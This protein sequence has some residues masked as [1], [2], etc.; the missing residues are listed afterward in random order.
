MR[1]LIEAQ[2][3]QRRG[4][5]QAIAPQLRLGGHGTT[6]ADAMDSLQSVAAAWA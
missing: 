6:E 1:L 2:V 4:G 5:L 3:S